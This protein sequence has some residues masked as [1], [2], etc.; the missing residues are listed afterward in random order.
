ME[1]DDQLVLLPILKE[2]EKEVVQVDTSDHLITLST[3]TSIIKRKRN[4]Q[5]I[6]NEFE[7]EDEQTKRSK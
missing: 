7:I 2:K 1:E 5:E 4:N 6:R 3:T